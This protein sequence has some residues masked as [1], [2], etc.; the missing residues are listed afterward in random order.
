MT[1]E[2]ELARAQGDGESR[3]MVAIPTCN[4][5]EDLARLLESLGACRVPD[6]T[7]CSVLIVENGTRLPAAPV[8]EG[9]ELF[10][11][12]VRLVVEPRKGIP[13]ARNAALD[14]A[15][16]EGFDYLAFADDDETVDADWL[17]SLFACLK[18]S[19][20]DL[21]GGPV[22]A[23]RPPIE[24]SAWQTWLMRGYERWYDIRQV[25]NETQ[26][27]RGAQDRITVLTNN[28]LL[29]LGFARREGMRFSDR[30]R[31]SGGSDAHFCSE[32]RKLG[33][34]TAWCTTAAVYETVLP[35]RLSARY[36]LFRG[37]QQRINHLERGRER[38]WS[39]YAQAVA[40]F[41]PLLAYGLFR[42]VSS[43]LVGPYAFFDGVRS[44]GRAFGGIMGVF[45][46]RS[47]LYEIG[48]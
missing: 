13:F 24:L 33:G 1:G 45:G 15:L 27:R 25:R 34:V 47:G 19:S 37:A 41:L 42:T 32:L 48:D 30:F 9:R 38:G 11:G 5:P 40:L 10:G 36:I 28:W 31:I 12:P 21:A 6:Q 20:A 43:P 4:R 8:V 44:C 18:A 2:V 7:H 16:A 39:I 46:A 35:E 14:R 22:Y 3:I 17:V 26:L 29:D 23:R